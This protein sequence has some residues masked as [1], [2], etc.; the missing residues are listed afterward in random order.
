MEELGVGST[1]VC[2]RCVHKTTGKHY[3]CK[4]ID[5]QMIEERFQGMMEQFHTEIEALRALHHPSIIELFDVYIS[6]EKIFI[7]MELMEGG[8]LFDYVVQ[9]GTLTEDEASDIV[10]KVTSAMVYM[11]SQ[12]I[13]HRDLKPENLLLYR[14]PNNPRDTVDIKIIDFGLSKCMTEPVAQSFLGTRGYLAP[15]MLQRRN[16][17]KAVDTWALG[18]IVFVLLCGCLPFDDD[19]ATVPTDELVRAKF[20]LRFPRWAKNLSP[21]AK[22]LLSHLLDVNPNRRYT[23]EQ[24]LDH[25]WVTGKSAPKGNLLASPGRIKKSPTLRKGR[26][27]PVTVLSLKVGSHI[28]QHR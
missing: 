22:D 1:S 15:E 14:K 25:P 3:A 26:R 2:H 27:H 5:K 16:Y 8:E 20:V 11:H 13:V 19:S 24:A 7:V 10:R 4:I 18:V 17:T 21:S 12:N 28:E 6:E 23:A 9:K